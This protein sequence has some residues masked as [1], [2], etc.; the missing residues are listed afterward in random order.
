MDKVDYKQD[1]IQISQI[2]ENFS[3]KTKT[4]E[5]EYKKTSSML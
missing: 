4:E 2:N 1:I 3:V 5:P